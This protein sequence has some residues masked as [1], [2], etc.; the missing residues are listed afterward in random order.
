MV[1]LFHLHEIPEHEIPSL[2][3]PLKHRSSFIA[4]NVNLKSSRKN[5]GSPW[6]CNRAGDSWGWQSQP[7]RVLACW[8]KRGELW[9]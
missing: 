4:L 7:Q 3:A 8:E 6:I 2:L 9:D 5:E 1:G